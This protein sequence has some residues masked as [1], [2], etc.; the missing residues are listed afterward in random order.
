LQSEDIWQHN[1]VPLKPPAK[2]RIKSVAYA[3]PNFRNGFFQP[4]SFHSY[5]WSTCEEGFKIRFWSRHEKPHFTG[6][7]R[8]Q[9]LPFCSQRASNNGL[10][11]G[12]GRCDDKSGH[13]LSTFSIL[14]SLVATLPSKMES[15]EPFTTTTAPLSPPP[16][17]EKPSLGARLQE[18]MNTFW[19]YEIIA[20]LVSVAMLAAIFGVLHHYNGWDVDLWNF[21]WSLG[22]L[23]GLLATIS[24]VAMAVPLASGISQLKWTW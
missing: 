21:S 16:V 20:S 19:V 9:P 10:L 4:L 6:L 2:A 12:C 17:Y 18:F 23:I 13:F 8:R 22:S 7:Q 1:H 11:L 15:K 3:N 5:V 24:Q 14:Q